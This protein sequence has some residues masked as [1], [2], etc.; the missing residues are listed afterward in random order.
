MGAAYALGAATVT[1][2]LHSGICGRVQIRDAIAYLLHRYPTH[3][4]HL[5]EFSGAAPPA[6]TNSCVA[7]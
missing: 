3:V 1:L 7:P 6:R 4:A 2:S 5:K